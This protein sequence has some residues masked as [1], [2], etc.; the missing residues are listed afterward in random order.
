MASIRTALQVYADLAKLLSI[1][2]IER[3]PVANAQASLLLTFHSPVDNSR[4]MNSAWLSNAIRYA[5][6]ARADVY[7]RFRDEDPAKSRMLKRLWWAVV[8]RDRVLSLALRRSAQVEIDPS[9][10]DGNRNLLARHV[11]S[12]DDFSTELG[13]SP[14]H[15][16]DTQLRIVELNA[17]FCRLFQCLALPL[18]LLY[19][20]EGI[21]GSCHRVTSKITKLHIF[22]L[23]RWLRYVRPSTTFTNI[24]QA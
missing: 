22:P 15:G 23:P 18:K 13:Q 20:H 24:I 7:Y 6:M 4:R 1:F 17:T 8:F 21:F 14:V 10:E 3:N 2:E 19:H 11:L 16:L 12:A 5:R 9:W